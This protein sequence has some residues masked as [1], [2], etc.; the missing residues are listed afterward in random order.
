MVAIYLRSKVTKPQ[1]PIPFSLI[2][3]Q[4][5]K[6]RIPSTLARPFLSGY[7]IHFLRCN[8][9]ASRLPLAGIR[10]RARER[11]FRTKDF[12][13]VRRIRHRRAFDPRIARVND[14][15]RR[16]APPQRTEKLERSVFAA[17]RGAV[18]P[19]LQR[20]ISRPSLCFITSPI[21]LRPLPSPHTPGQGAFLDAAF[22]V[23]R[24][25]APSLEIYP[26]TG[27]SILLLRKL[28]FISRILLCSQ[29]EEYNAWPSGGERR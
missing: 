29:L 27:P 14:K 28:A 26:A 13:H 5:E 19:L 15:R 9:L 23:C 17:C 6:K 1:P 21:L 7:K 22:Q 10:L 24:W 25:R 4:W 12:Q 20:C 2:Q 11:P 16:I 18:S 8:R 3:N